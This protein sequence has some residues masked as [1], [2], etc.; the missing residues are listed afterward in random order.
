MDESSPLA[1]DYAT[2]IRR[3]IEMAERLSANDPEANGWLSPATEKELD[4]IGLFLANALKV[5]RAKIDV[6]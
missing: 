2:I 1:N 4:G 5:D 3:M 6:F